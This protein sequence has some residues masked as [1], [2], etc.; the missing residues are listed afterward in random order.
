MDKGLWLVA[1]LYD[2]TG[3]KIDCTDG[4]THLRL[5]NGRGEVFDPQPITEPGL[6]G[7]ENAKFAAIADVRR[8]RNARG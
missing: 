5:R 2:A 3:N 1:D 6:L 4:A 8:Q 7:V